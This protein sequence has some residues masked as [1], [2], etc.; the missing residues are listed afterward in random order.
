MSADHPIALAHPQCRLDDAPRAK[1]QRG[2]P[3][4]PSVFE[5][6]R[7]HRLSDVVPLREMRKGTLYSSTDRAK[8]PRSP[9]DYKW[10]T[11]SRRQDIRQQPTLVM[12]KTQA[13]ARRLATFSPRTAPLL[14]FRE[15]TLCCAAQSA[16][17]FPSPPRPSALHFH[18]DVGCEFLR[19]HRHRLCGLAEGAPP[20]SAL[21]MRPRRLRAAS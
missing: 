4:T 19:C 5:H 17:M 21:S 10:R 20:P 11:S 7:L 15:R 2:P 6:A 18:A 12:R 1:G 14:E 8:F 13:L 9:W 3:A 16:L